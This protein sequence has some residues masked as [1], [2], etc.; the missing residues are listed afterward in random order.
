MSYSIL[1]FRFSHNRI[2]LLDR[3]R[4]HFDGIYTFLFYLRALEMERGT[5]PATDYMLLCIF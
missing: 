4:S 3:R 5:L 2:C 1:L